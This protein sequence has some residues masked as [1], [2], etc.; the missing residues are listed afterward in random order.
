MT[1]QKLYAAV[2]QHADGG[3]EMKMCKNPVACRAVLDFVAMAKVLLVRCENHT[4]HY[5]VRFKAKDIEY[6]W[7]AQYVNNRM[8]E[9]ISELKTPPG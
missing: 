7:G 5:I 1:G 9:A 8:R 4:T 6:E 2:Q 3:L